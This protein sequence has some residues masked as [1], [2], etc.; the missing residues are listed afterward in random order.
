MDSFIDV[1]RAW[2][3]EE[4]RNSLTP[5]QLAHLPLSP[6]GDVELSEDELNMVTGGTYYNIGNYYYYFG[7]VGGGTITIGPKPP[8]P[9]PGGH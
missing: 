4:Y 9:G 7:P 6:A 8:G 1:A 3:D 2:K 5:D